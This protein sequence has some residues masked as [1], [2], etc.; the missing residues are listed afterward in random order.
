MKLLVTLRASAETP[1]NARH[2]HQRVKS[3]F[4]HWQN[5]QLLPAVAMESFID[6]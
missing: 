2:V 4:V 1:V 3:T 6:R 5:L